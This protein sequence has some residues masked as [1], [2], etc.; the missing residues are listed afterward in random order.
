[1]KLAKEDHFQ[2]V[3]FQAKT[4]D[5]TNVFEK[6][7]AIWKRLFPLKPFNGFYQNEA[8]AES[9][10]VSRSIAQIFS[11][12]SVI[13]ILLTATGLFALVSLTMLKRMREIALRKVVGASPADILVLINKGYFWIF[14]VSAILGCYGGWSLTKLLL[15]MIF[16][17]NVGIE[18]STLLISVIILFVITACTIG[19][20][21]WQAV[22]INPV[23]LLRME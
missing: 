2:F 15:D 12:F 16:K 11:W 17:V 1:M 7:K 8:T 21:V 19:I 4:A 5:L 3:I 23:K 20:K 6:A 18:S 9:Y 22:K 14:F 10:R 13:S